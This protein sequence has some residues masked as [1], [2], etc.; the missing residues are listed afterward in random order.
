[1]SV[2]AIAEKTCMTGEKISNVKV[3][4]VGGFGIRAI[5]HMVKN[6]LSD[7]SLVKFLAVDTDKDV[8]QESIADTCCLKGP[9]LATK[10]GGNVKPVRDEQVSLS[11]FGELES[12]LT[13]SDMVFIVSGMGGVT[14]TGVTP[15]IVKLSKEIGAITIAVMTLP[16]QFEG[17]SR[18]GSAM[19]GLDQLQEYADNT[20][21]IQNASMLLVQERY[22]NLSDMLETPT[23]NV[24][25]LVEMII[26]STGVKSEIK[27]LLQALVDVEVMGCR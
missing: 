5:N 19:S 25:L 2:E 26:R 7:L 4:G 9:Y 27:G 11:S 16:F 18:T 24:M 23:K 10:S 13:G 17:K 3:I 15:K 8:L 12:F 21:V 20:L 22:S 6:G 1:M 14:G